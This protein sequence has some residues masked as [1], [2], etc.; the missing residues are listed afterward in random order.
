MVMVVAPRS[1]C[2]GSVFQYYSKPNIGDRPAPVG[3]VAPPK[4]QGVPQHLR[5]LARLSRA[6]LPDA[7]AV[8]VSAIVVHS[9]V[10]F[11]MH[12]PANALLVVTVMGL[13]VALDNGPA[14]D[15]YRSQSALA[16]APAD[17][18]ERRH[19]ARQAIAAYGTSE[20]MLRLGIFYRRIGDA[21]RALEAF[22]R[23][24]QLGARDQIAVV[25]IQDIR[26]SVPVGR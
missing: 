21:E 22:E 5:A 8:A 23:S 9:F 24:G 11:N 14:G 1:P 26:R 13:T 2:R 16:S 3:G 12:I 7:A 18:A 4:R 15:V 17:E 25:N 19:L 6:A 10:D 20:V